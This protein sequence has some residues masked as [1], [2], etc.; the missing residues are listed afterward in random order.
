VLVLLGY[1]ANA[2]YQTTQGTTALDVACKYQFGD[3]C[4]ILKAATHTKGK[5]YLFKLFDQLVR[6]TKR[7]ADGE[8]AAAGT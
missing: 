4:E 5:R 1:G 6:K 7:P 8:A 3:T 2:G